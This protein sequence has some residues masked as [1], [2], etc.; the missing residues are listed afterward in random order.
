[1]RVR[2]SHELDFPVSA[3]VAWFSDLNAEE[4]NPYWSEMGSLAETLRRTHEGK[5]PSEIPG[6]ES[7]RRLYRSFGKTPPGIARLLKLCLRRALQGKDLYQINRLV[8]AS[9]WASLALLLPIGL[10]DLDKVQGDLELRRG[11]QGESYEGIRRGLIQATS[12]LVVA[13]SRGPCGSP[14][15]DSLRTSISPATSRAAAVVF[16]PGG[17]PR[18]QL[19]EGTLRLAAQVTSWCGGSIEGTAVLTSED[20]D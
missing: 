3:G 2:L 8:D 9:N 14:T 12:R 16:A 15:A 20:D 7:A 6:L 17:F 4:E 1:M 18:L 19:E 10:Y 5:K 13:D 11:Q